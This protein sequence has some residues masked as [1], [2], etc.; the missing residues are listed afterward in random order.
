MM[1]LHVSGL[2]KQIENN[3]IVKD[4]NF[5]QKK[6]QKI[7]IAGETGSGKSTLLKMI[8]GLVQPDAGTILFENKIME[9]PNEKLVPG[10]SEIAYLSQH[11]EL[12][13]FLRVEQVLGYANSLSTR[14]ANSIYTICQINHLLQRKTDQLSGGEKQRIAI[15]RLLISKP[16]LLLLDEPFSNLDMVLREILKSV[17]DNIMKKLRITCVL[18]SHDPADT[19]SW[20]DEILVMKD[21]KIVQQGAP[22]IIY[23]NPIN[24]YVAGLFG[25]FN[26]LTTSI[27]KTLGVNSKKVKRIVRPEELRIKKLKTKNRTSGLVSDVHFLG[28][29]YEIAVVLSGRSLLCFSKKNSFKIGDIVSISVSK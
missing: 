18:V 21:G 13:K 16:K 14:E 2:G 6:Y 3:W 15:A 5:V 20:A 24:E 4:I 10:H 8:G 7:V 11:F 29:H 1:L 27:I 12:P 25:I 26:V 9:G 19:L 23:Q 17:I 28:T 22:E